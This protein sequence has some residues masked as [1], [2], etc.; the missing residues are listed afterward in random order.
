MRERGERRMRRLESARKVCVE[1]SVMAIPWGVC[2]EQVSEE[3]IDCDLVPKSLVD[4][5][6]FIF[7]M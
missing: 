2:L 5:Q 4:V 3:L 1:T 6:S 7:K